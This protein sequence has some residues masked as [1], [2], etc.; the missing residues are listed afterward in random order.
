MAPTQ[1]LVGRSKTSECYTVLYVQIA[2]RGLP[3]SNTHGCSMLTS[4]QRGLLFAGNGCECR[5]ASFFEVKKECTS[6]QCAVAPDPPYICTWKL[7]GLRA[8][9]VEEWGF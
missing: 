4:R 3:T 7:T 6:V 1:C 2:S 9:P 5:A 8:E